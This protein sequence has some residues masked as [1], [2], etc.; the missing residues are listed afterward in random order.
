MQ[1]NKSI[2]SA[3]QKYYLFQFFGNLAFFS[4]VIVLFW[5]ANG[6]TM[7]QIMLLQSIYAI[8]VSV[9]ELPTGA[10]A[11]LFG[12]KLSLFIGAF[13]WTMGMIWYGYSHSFWQFALGE[14]TVGLGAAFIS[15]ADRA[16]LHHIL[17]LRNDEESFNKIEG[18]ARGFIQIAQAL[19]SLVGGFIGSFSLAATLFATSISNFFNILL[20]PTFPPI[21]KEPALKPHYSEL[22][23]DS[24]ST[25][26]NHRELLWYTLFFGFFNAFVWPLQFYAQEYLRMLRLPVYFFGIT[27]MMCNILAAI[28][29]AYTHQFDKAVK[30]SSFFILSLISSVTLLILMLFPSVYM[31]PLWSLFLIAAFMNQT[32]ISGR[33]LNIVPHEKAATVLSIQ[34]LL[35]RL[36][37]ALIIPFLGMITDSIGMRPALM[38]YS[39][40][41][42]GLLG[43]LIFI[44]RNFK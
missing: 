27:F 8:G 20:V 6:L 10:F 32:I 36:I 30:D 9:L 42:F 23:K 38:G 26:L 28:G 24:I 15:G 44:R 35:R 21:K 12:K 17:R 5:R 34:N 41:M 19:A 37:Y 40:L 13:F 7:A 14:I 18:R 22:I 3:V 43:F 16:Y 33:V 2:L 39:F 11:D 31:L 4:P 29:L 1:Q 25:V